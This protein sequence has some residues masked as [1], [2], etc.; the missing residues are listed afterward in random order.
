MQKRSYIF[1]L[2]F[3]LLLLGSCSEYQKVVKG[4]NYEEKFLLANSMYAKENYS[5][6][7]GLY[8][9]VYQRFPKVDKGVVSYY[10]LG[11]CYFGQEDYYMAG[12]Y[13]SQFT[14]RYPSSEQAEEA[15]FMNAI[16]SVKNS[17]KATLDQKDTK[18]AL[19]DLQLFIQRYPDSDL[20]DSCNRTMDRLRFKLETKR[21]DAVQLYS[22][23][24]DHRAAVASAASFLEDY[25]RSSYIEE[26]A[27]I[28]CE[29]AYQLA[30]KSVLSKKKE[31]IERAIEAFSKY[32]HL[33]E[34]K[35][36]RKQRAKQNDKLTE[37][38]EKVNERYAYND[39]VR[40]FRSSNSSSKHK[41]MHYLK[42][43]ITRFNNF[44][45]NYPNSDLYDKAKSLN[46]KA[47]KELKNL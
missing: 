35:S 16:C 34:K 32:D 2:F 31:R 8:E 11:K 15:L 42:E 20:I 6:A 19:N 43:T 47:E 44:A 39:I 7:I 9:Q 26:A 14:L 46:S 45:E 38:L 33:F 36:Y 10:R 4:N 28:L 29:N 25:P 12:Y 27:S 17:P 22:K 5:K 23:M 21:F 3:S 37:E 24:E 30:M 41:K 18:K 40:A 13:F 1:L